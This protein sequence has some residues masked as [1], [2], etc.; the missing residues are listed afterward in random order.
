MGLG[1]MVRQT[2][3][4]YRLMLLGLASIGAAMFSRGAER[5]NYSP[6]RSTPSPLQL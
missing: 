4:A 6:S 2:S 3:N 5:N 1:M